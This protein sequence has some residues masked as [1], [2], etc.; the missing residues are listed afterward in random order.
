MRYTSIFKDVAGKQ[1]AI[2]ITTEGVA[3]PLREVTPGASPFTTE[4]S[5]NDNLYTP[6]RLSTAKVELLQDNGKDFMM[7][8]YSGEAHGTKVELLRAEA[9]GTHTYQ[10]GDQ[11]VKAVVEWTGYATPT[12][13][14]GDYKG[15]RDTISLE[16]IDGVASLKYI[17][18][19]RTG[20]I[21]SFLDIIRR[22]LR[23]CD[24]YKAFYFSAAT[25]LPD[26]TSCI[27]DDLY[28]SEQNFFASKDD[29]TQTDSDVAWTCL[30]VIEEICRYLNVYVTTWGEYVYFL[31]L[32]AVRQGKNTYYRYSVADDTA[33]EKATLF[34]SITVDGSL[35]RSDGGTLSLDEVYNRIKVKDNFNSYDNVLPDLFD[36]A[37][38]I[39]KDSD[40]DKEQRKTIDDKGMGAVIYSSLQTY[41]ET[42]KNMEVLFISP[43]GA[44]F[45]VFIKYYKNPYYKT[46]RYV[47]DG[48]KLVERNLDS[49]NFTDT[50]DSYGAYILRTCTVKLTKNVLDNWW[51]KALVDMGLSQADIIQAALEIAGTGSISLED[52][53]M[54]SNPSLHHIPNGQLKKYPFFETENFE[55]LGLAGGKGVYILISG[56]Y[57]YQKYD[58]PFMSDAEED[59][60]HGRYKA[61]VADCHLVAMLKWGD[62]YWNGNPGKGDNGWVKQEYTFNI[63][64]AKEGDNTRADNMMWKDVQ[65]SNNVRWD[66]GIDAEGYMIPLPNST[67]ISG[68][69]KFTLYKPYD[70]TYYSDKSGDNE[71]Q[72]YKHNQVFLKDF[73][74]SLVKADPSREADADSD[75]TYTNVIDLNNVADG[76]EED[77]KITTDDNKMPAYSSVAVKSGD[78]YQWLG[79]TVNDATIAAQK[80][81]AVEDD[82]ASASETGQMRQEQHRVFRY[83]NQYSSPAV[84]IS[85][86][87]HNIVKPWSLIDE[88]YIGKKLILDAQNIDYKRST[89]EISTREMK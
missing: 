22:I 86:T 52:R 77:F 89:S 80:S 1:H 24:C 75:T 31:D 69:P 6:S 16:C 11:Q 79:D 34:D 36:F 64:Y 78:G 35:Y 29:R 61:D 85:F 25:H 56:S 58:A 3:A 48:S 33:G 14:D 68:V 44:I 20:K 74:I 60:G 12:T 13:Y 50:Q 87:A 19:K 73:K 59:L 41:G 9:D 32:D 76:E 2:V 71:G 37:E 65:I 23:R 30:D 27:I 84:K 62:L 49:I 43:Y 70:P 82:D 51:L 26:K 57:R 67:L 38:N 4:M 8:M 10:D 88:P 5:S 46:H 15:E 18:Y 54:L 63:P 45:A 81:W 17:K 47:W 66:S 21:T 42:K 72:Y 53:I 39:T 7:D 40:P 55:G 83:V 28:I